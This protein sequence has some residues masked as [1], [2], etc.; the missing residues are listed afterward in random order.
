MQVCERVQSVSLRHSPIYISLIL[1]GQGLAQQ[2]VDC[3]D[4]IETLRCFDVKCFDITLHGDHPNFLSGIFETVNSK[5]IFVNARILLWIDLYLFLSHYACTSIWLA[6]QVNLDMTDHCT[7][8]FCIWWTICLVPVRCISSIRHMYMTDFAYDGPI[9]LVP[10]SL[11]YPSSSVYVLGSVVK[12]GTTQLSIQVSP[13]LCLFLFKLFMPRVGLGIGC[14]FMIG[15]QLQPTDRLSII[16][17][18][19]H[20]C[21]NWVLEV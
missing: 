4:V 16:I 18:S 2:G 5:Q 20:F 6:I 8:D 12:D 13:H 10:L 3:R 9:F 14:N 19:S 15:N 21:I 17:S 11:S 7:T 1:Q